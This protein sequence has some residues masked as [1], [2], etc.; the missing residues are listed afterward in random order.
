MKLFSFSPCRSLLLSVLP[1]A[2][3]SASPLFAGTI[4][5]PDTGAIPPTMILTAASTGN[6]EGY[7]DSYSAGDTDFIYMEDLTT[8]H[9]STDYFDNKTTAPG[10]AVNFG[11][12][13]AGDQL[14]FFLY[15]QTTGETFSSDPALNADGQN[16]AYVTPYSGVGGPAGIP[17]GLYIGMEDLYIPP[18]DLDYNDDTFVVTNVKASPAVPEPSSLALFGSGLLG[19]AGAF[20]RRVKV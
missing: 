15:N 10:T 5:Y 11:A 17:A 7:F 6:V 2:A 18:S 9:I 19:L 14:A 16:H 4:P 8:G 3:L 13:T 12:V 20:R 1:F